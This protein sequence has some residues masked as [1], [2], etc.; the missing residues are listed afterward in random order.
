[1]RTLRKICI[2]NY[3]GGTGK[4]STTVNLAHGLS[5]KGKRVLVIDTDPQGSC[6][7]YLSVKSKYTLYDLL[8]N[9]APLKDCIVQARENLDII[10]SNERLYP[11]ELLMA[12]MKFRDTILSQKLALLESQY[13]FIFI[14]CAPSLNLLNQNALRFCNEVFIPVS[15]DILSLVGVRQ[16]IN[17]I[18]I[19][20]TL[21]TH[22]IEV[23]KVIPTFFDNRNK[24][25]KLVIN[26]I[27]KVFSGV[28]TS[29]IRTCV[30]ISESAGY[31]KTI[32]EFAP[33][34]KGAIDYW[35]LT[36]EVI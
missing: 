33:K 7:Y 26:S 35:Q 8:T 3:K 31:K 21:T 1:M 19:L 15:M 2:I 18:K 10:I 11:A 20:N 27:N 6:S 12:K 5:Q 29:P 13:D 17:N 14:D 30:S 24:K 34:S 36:K 16:L 25:T 28:I 9:Q 23:S 32:F 4:T 22:S